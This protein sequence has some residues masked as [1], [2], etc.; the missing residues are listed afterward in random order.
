MTTQH[1]KAKRWQFGLPDLM[2]IA[3][4]IPMLAGIFSGTFGSDAIF[5]YVVSLV[6]VLSLLAKRGYTL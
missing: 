4:V 5:M 1:D 3:A 2:V 6:L